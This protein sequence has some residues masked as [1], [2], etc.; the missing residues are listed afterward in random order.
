[1]TYHMSANPT[2]EDK[3]YQ[4]EHDCETLIDA[5][6]IMGDKARM[7][8]AMKVAK[9]KMAALKAVHDYE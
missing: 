6:E 7:K 1:M 8:A 5:Q 2:A 4:A 9:E 3:R